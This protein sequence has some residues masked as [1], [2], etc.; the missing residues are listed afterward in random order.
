VGKSKVLIERFKVEMAKFV[1]ITDMGELH[2]IL[3]IEV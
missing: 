2:W 1:E 3:G